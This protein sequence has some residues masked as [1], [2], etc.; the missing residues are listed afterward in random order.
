MKMM[1][2]KPDHLLVLL[3]SKLRGS[4]PGRWWMRGFLPQRIFLRQ[5]R[6]AGA[7]IENSRHL[8]HPEKNPF[9]NRVLTDPSATAAHPSSDTDQNHRRQSAGA[10]SSPSPAP[11]SPFSSSA[12]STFSTPISRRISCLS[13]SSVRPREERAWVNSASPGNC[14]RN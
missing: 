10:G 4:L 1:F 5:N 14:W 11:V 7:E 9:L 12:S 2:W 3:D 8:S 6:R 13:P